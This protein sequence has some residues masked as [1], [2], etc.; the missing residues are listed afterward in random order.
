MNL[1]YPGRWLGGVLYDDGGLPVHCPMGVTAS[2]EGP[3]GEQDS[4]YDHDGC[5]CRYPECVGV[6][7]EFGFPATKMKAG[8]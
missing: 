1:G 3:C 6:V 4:D 5:W 7:D 8:Q 2:G